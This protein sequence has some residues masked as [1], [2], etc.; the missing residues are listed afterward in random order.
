MRKIKIFDKKYT[1]LSGCIHNHTKYSWDSQEEIET[2]IKAALSTGLDYV[3]IN[4]HLTLQAKEDKYLQNLK[5]PI[6]I[7][8]AE[9]NDRDNKNHYLVYKTD[10]ILKGK[11]AS[12][13]TDFY[14][15]ENAYRFAAHP[16]EKRL[17]SEFNTYE[18]TNL[19]NTK[20]D[21]LEIWNA[22]SDWLGKMIPKLNG[23]FLVMFPN[24]F[25]TGADKEILKY[26]DKLNREGKKCSAIGSTDAHTIYLKKF[27]LNFKF[28]KHKYMFQTIR[29]NVWVPDTKAINKISILEALKNGNSYIYNYKRGIPYKFLAGIKGDKIK[30]IPGDSI[31][32]TKNLKFYYH[33]PKI[34]KVLLFRDGELVYKAHNDKGAVPVKRKG[35]Y[36]LQI[37][38]WGKGWIYTNNI[39]VE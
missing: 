26:W 29:T 37:H 34:A 4:D 12:E 16:I 33:L 35:N 30:A 25:I 9:I 28:L 14:T 5:K 18:W 17:S 27:G 3:T 38:K 39:Y 32:F 21:G 2:V 31:S 11:S 20:F 13:Y 8:G 19:N 7:V 22:V 6:V 10:K 36:R 24:L 23:L 15:K 1:E